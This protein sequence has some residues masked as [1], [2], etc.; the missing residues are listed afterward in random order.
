MP[1]TT[2]NRDRAAELCSEATG[3]PYRTSRSWAARGL[4]T[5]RCPV[6]DADHPD[7]RALEA[8]VV[9]HLTGDPL[10]SGLLSIT[11]VVPARD[12]LEVWLCPERARQ[13][14]ALLLPRWDTVLGGLGG[15]VGL[16][17]AREGSALRLHSLVH[18]GSVLI[19]HPD[20]A[21]AESFFARRSCSVH[22][23]R[24][25]PERLHEDERDWLSE[26]AG[27][28]AVAVAEPDRDRLLSRII[29][30]SRLLRAAGSGHAWSG[31]YSEGRRELAIEWCCATEP[32]DLAA[33]LRRSGLTVGPGGVERGEGCT[34]AFGG[35]TVTMRRLPCASGHPRVLPAC[36]TC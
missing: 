27:D 18:G 14:M 19:R 36:S 13:V 9:L 26:P 7:Q 25:T 3:V 28:D 11:R 5:R 34:L 17:P 32:E 15:I 10:K 29:R 16:R 8:A 31:T 4:I 21:W 2:R 35:A 20:P 1:G 30:R 24:D 22:I 12:G 23:W 33:R 6:P